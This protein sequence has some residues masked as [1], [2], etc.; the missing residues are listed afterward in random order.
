MS[1]TPG[2]MRGKNLL[3]EFNVV[4][5][6]IRENLLEVKQKMIGMTYADLNE[7]FAKRGLDYDLW[8]LEWEHAR[9]TATEGEIRRLALR[10]RIEILEREVGHYSESHDDSDD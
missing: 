8:A 6:K 3:H 7:E 2:E 4:A 1:E 9:V 10:M 5:A